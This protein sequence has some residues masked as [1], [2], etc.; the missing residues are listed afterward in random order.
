MNSVL[1]QLW[2]IDPGYECD[3][4]SAFPYHAVRTRQSILSD[5]IEYHVDIFSDVFELLFRVI[6]H[7][8]GAEFFEQFLVG[9]RSRSDHLCAARLRDLDCK[10]S[11]AARSTMNEHGLAVA[12]LRGVNQRLPRRQSDNR[13]R[14]GL[15]VSE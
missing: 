13:H 15:H 10:S 4:E 9:G 2:L 1:I 14:C 6:D 12:K 11:Y 7:D 5:R 3:D 8:I